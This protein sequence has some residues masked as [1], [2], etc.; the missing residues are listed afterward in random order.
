MAGSSAASSRETVSPSG[1][2]R[3]A[4]ARRAPGVCQAR[5]IGRMPNASA[6]AGQLVGPAMD[7]VRIVEL[8]I[9]AL[10]SKRDV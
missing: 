10:T 6:T 8:L 2:L 4:G 5:S 9:L 1:R 3:A 7:L